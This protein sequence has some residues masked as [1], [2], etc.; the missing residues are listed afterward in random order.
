MY[1]DVYE[2]MAR[3]GGSTI[4]VQGSR[5]VPTWAFI[6]HLL[7]WAGLNGYVYWK[8]LDFAIEVMN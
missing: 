7:W 5:V 1:G 4:E 8:L 6:R 2:H 3:I